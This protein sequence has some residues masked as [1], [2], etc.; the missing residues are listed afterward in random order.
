MRVLFAGEESQTCT[1]A[2]RDKGRFSGRAKKQNISMNC[3][4]HGFSVGMILSFIAYNIH[5]AIQLKVVTSVSLPTVAM[6]L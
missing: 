4:S 1:I 2:F 3:C 5:F 6:S